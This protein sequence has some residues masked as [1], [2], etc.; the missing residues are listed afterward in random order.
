M[1]PYYDPGRSP[2]PSVTYNQVA[3]RLVQRWA[4]A[5]DVPDPF[6]DKAALDAERLVYDYLLY[7]SGGAVR[8]ATASGEGSFN[9]AELDTV[10]G[11]VRENMGAWY[12]GG[13]GGSSGGSGLIV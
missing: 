8:S 11:I 10:K 7:T 12:T 9:A 4:P 6:Y 5:P 3:A 13:A 1:E 2:D